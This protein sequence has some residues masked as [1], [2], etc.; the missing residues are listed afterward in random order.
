VRHAIHEDDAFG[1]QKHATG[2]A[3]RPRDLGLPRIPVNISGRM[4]YF[5]ATADV[6]GYP[7]AKLTERGLP[8]AALTAEA[9]WQRLC[10]GLMGERFRLR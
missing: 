10:Y 6:I 5:A 1:M 2:A 7:I 8:V 3:D 4:E 9:R